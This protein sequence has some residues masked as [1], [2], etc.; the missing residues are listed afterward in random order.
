M[1][2]R[3][4]LLSLA[5]TAGTVAML[6]AQQAPAP[7]TGLGVV[8]D[9]SAQPGP[10]D[11]S[12]TRLQIVSEIRHEGAPVKSIAYTVTDGAGRV[13]LDVVDTPPRLKYLDDSRVLY[14]ASEALAPGHYRMTT[15]ALDEKGRRGSVERSFE[16]PAWPT[17]PVRVGDLVLGD[18]VRGVFRP[19][20]HV[21]PETRQIGVRLDVQGETPESLQGIT[22]TLVVERAGTAEP[23]ARETIPL[24]V[25]AS[26]RDRG[27]VVVLDVSRFE[28]GEYRLTA[29]V[30][31][32]QGEIQKKVRTLVR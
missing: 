8:V 7:L 11:P 10:A 32:E 9:T 1:H 15:V 12:D 19:S 13:V 4:V 25:M 20:A 2:L 24:S 22:A 5:M 23:I 3:R 27:G 29:I 30:S 16:I 6:S 18:V 21:D 14:L 17:H 31:N 28:T 26:R